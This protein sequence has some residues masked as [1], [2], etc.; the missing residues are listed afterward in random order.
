MK[1][2]INKPE[3]VVTEMLE[4]LLAAHP[5]LL[6]SVDNVKNLVRKDAPV[7][8]KVGI[9]S[10]GGS[11][12]LPL[13][14]GYIGKGML[15]GVA[16]GEIF[17]SP[18]SKQILDVTKSVDSGKGVLYLY[19]NYGGDV[20]NFDMAGEM[21]EMEGIRTATVIGTDDVASMP[22][23]QE[24]Q[25]R[26]VAGLFYLYKIAAAKAE[27]GAT[28]EEVAEIARF[29]NENVRTMGV[30]L[31]PCTLPEVGKPTFT[32]EDGKMELGM[33]IHGEPGYYKGA[34]QTADEVAETLVEKIYDDLSLE[35]GCE[36]SV[37]VNGLGATPLEELYI[38]FRKV[39]NL[40]EEKNIAINKVYIGEYATSLEMAGLSISVLKLNDELKRLLNAPFVT[41]FHVQ[42]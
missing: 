16:V 36:V 7:Q 24:S 10:G 23:G 17:A 11:G 19:G 14:L 33:G 35:D 25:R 8:N 9:V 38:V 37:L 30:A 32:I 27:E 34:I 18:S 5:D 2:F 20:M 6:K 42:P 41:P 31:S 39:K 4:G 1:K 12:H 26:G 13:F 40:F 3:N 21:A 15:D 28:L 29:T 22:K